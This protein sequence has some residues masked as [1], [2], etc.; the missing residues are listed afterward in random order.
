MFK[1]HSCHCY[2][3]AVS[4]LCLL[5]LLTTFGL[6]PAWAGTCKLNSPTV[7]IN[8]TVPLSGNITVGRDVPIGTELYRTT[9]WSNVT[10]VLGCD[11]GNYTFQKRLATTPYPKANWTA[12]RGAVAYQTNIPGIGVHIWSNSDGLPALNAGSYS[13]LV[14]TVLTLYLASGSI[15]A[16]TSFDVSIVKI[17]DTVGTGTLNGSSL[18]TVQFGISGT[19]FTPTLNAQITG[20]LNIVSRTC[21]TP[22][23]TVDLGTHYS[24][25]LTGVGSTTAWKTVPIALNNC[26]AFYNLNSIRTDTRSSPAVVTT[27]TLATNAIQYAVNPTTSVTLANQG[28]MALQSGGATGIGIQMADS[29]GNP[30]AYGQTQASGL[31]LTTVDGANYT[32]N[33]QARY[34]QTS[35]SPTLGAANG[36]ATITLVYQ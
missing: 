3:R 20:S 29:R 30:L 24:S 26:P 33:L 9:F 17:A 12:P 19:T 21:T 32:L 14:P 36:A 8:G 11:E 4:A 23:V 6:A 15:N 28:V 13:Y 1:F 35:A 27:G 5:L 25:E 7:P 2:R 34:Y 10:M 22:D 31:A 16:L 18:P